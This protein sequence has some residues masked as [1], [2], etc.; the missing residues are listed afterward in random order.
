M[1]KWMEAEGVIRR[2]KQFDVISRYRQGESYRHIARELGIDRKTVKAICDRYKKGID[3]LNSSKSEQEVEEATEQLVLTRSYDSSKRRTRAYTPAVEARMKELYQQ[4]L[5]KNKRLGPHKQALTAIAVHELLA[6]EGHPIGYRT[7]AH[8]WRQLKQKTREAFKQEKIKKATVRIEYTPGLSAQVDWKEEMKMIS[9]QGEIFTFNIFLYI[10]PY[11][12]K[13]YITLTFDRKQD[14]LFSCLND[15]F[16]YTGGVPEEIWFDNMKTVVDHS[17]TQFSKAQLNERFYAFSKDAGFRT[18]VYRPFRPQ[19]K[20]SVE[21]LAR[22][23]ERLR[24]YNHEFYDSVDLIHIVNDLC[25]EM[26]SEV[27]QATNEIPNL[28]WE[29]NEKE[30]LHKLKKDL[31]KPYFEDFITRKV[32]NEAMVN[33]RQCKYSVDPRYIGKEVEVELSEN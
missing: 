27:S 33:F 2:M 14:T 13:R 1:I 23:V 18:M 32:T 29:M 28:R 22:A 5:K 6:E 26:N 7:V 19:T 21:A 16:Y 3:A 15:A 31:L 24:V 17:R 11:S 8:Y 9:N 20:G 30:H 12:K 4:E 10:L 25:E